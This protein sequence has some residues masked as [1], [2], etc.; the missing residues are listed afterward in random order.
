[1]TKPIV[2]KA[3]L[4]I[5]GLIGVSIGAGILFVPEAFFATNNIVLAR[6]A[7]LLSEIRAPGGALLASGVLIITG[8]FIPTLTFTA[9]ALSSLMYLSYGVSRMIG[10]A[11][12]GMPGDGLVAACVLEMTIGALNLF[13][14]MKYRGTLQA[15][16]KRIA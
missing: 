8:A 5:S 11:L 7:N 2:L 12:D 4:L 15:K 3:I 13:V 16:I 9:L 6:D 1:M 14:L 10:M